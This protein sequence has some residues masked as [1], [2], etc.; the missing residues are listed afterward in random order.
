[1]N[2]PYR[3]SYTTSI[4]SSIFDYP[5]VNGRRYHA[6]KQGSYWGPNDEK[7]QERLALS[8]F[9]TVL[10]MYGDLFRSPIGESPQRILDIGTGTGEWAIEVADMFP[11]A[12]VI[13]IDLSPIQATMVPP[14]CEFHVDDAEAIWPYPVDEPFDLV[15]SRTLIGSIGNWP[16][17]FKQ[18]Y[19]HL[20][21]GGWVELQEVDVMAYSDDDSL[22]ADS[23]FLEYIKA[24]T[25]AAGM[26]G[27]PMDVVP[28]F[29]GYL[30]DAGFVMTKEEIFKMPHSPWPKDKH[31]KE[32]G[33]WTQI[34][35]LEALEAYGLLL[36]GQV[37]QWDN[38]RIQVLLAKVREELKNPNIHTYAKL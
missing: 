22:P 11:S 21:P 36:L 14:N 24:L 23:A 10:S 26:F 20:K 37:L 7:E 6:Y 13:G 25:Q 1:M 27:K 9:T 38:T 34:Q 29:E 28:K 18:V 5:F 30:R 32:I 4:T 8:H 33:R 17:L 31:M 15:H 2:K 16:G 12:K 3:N 35:S 19:Q